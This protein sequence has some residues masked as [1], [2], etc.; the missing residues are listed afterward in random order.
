MTMHLM[1]HAYSTINSR[2]RKPKMTKANVAKWTEECR[3]HNKLMKR[4]DGSCKTLEEYIDYIHGIAPKRNPLKDWKPMESKTSHF[5]EQSKKHREMYPSADI[6]THSGVCSKREPMQY[7]GTL[8]KGIAT[9][10][11][12]NAVPVIDEEHM[13]DIA[14]MRRG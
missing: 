7:T 8:V 10:H 9:M 13:K 2:K 14:R 12:S 5:H 11:K 4:I 6:K 1:S 3:Q